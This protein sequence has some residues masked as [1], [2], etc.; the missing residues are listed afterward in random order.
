MEC[1]GNAASRSVNSGTEYPRKKVNSTPR[2]GAG[3]CERNSSSYH[4]S[5]ADAPHTT[6]T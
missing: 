3:T 5:H 1:S 4:A 2:G 6:N